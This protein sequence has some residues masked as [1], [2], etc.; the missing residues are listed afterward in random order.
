MAKKHATSLMEMAEEKFV[1][2]DTKDINAPSLKNILEVIERKVSDSELKAVKEIGLAVGSVG[3]SL[4]DS[5]FRAR[6]TKDELDDLMTKVP[7]IRTYFHLKQVE[8]K[9]NLLKVVTTHANENKDVKIAMWLLEK[10]YGE[11][12]DSSLK[13]DIAKMNRQNPGDDV[14]EMAFAFVRRQNADAMPV[15]KRIGDAEDRSDI[16]IHDIKLDLV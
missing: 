4:T 7:E 10:Q 11:E 12:Y 5:C 1:D 14:V 6:V 8:Y 13:K 2:T 3:M 16:K 9:Y 15:N